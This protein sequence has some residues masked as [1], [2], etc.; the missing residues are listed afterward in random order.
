MQI[1]SS[2]IIIIQSAIA[3]IDT[4]KIH[5]CH[6]AQIKFILLITAYFGGS[7]KMRLH[8][9][10]NSDTHFAASLFSKS[11][12]EKNG[13]NSTQDI[14]WSLATLK[15][16]GFQRVS[17]TKRNTNILISDQCLSLLFFRGAQY[18]RNRLFLQW[19]RKLENPI[20]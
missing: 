1:L 8:M 20:F 19:F 15:I 13:S 2:K 4:S 17:N 14:Y 12:L 11:S 5:K 16:E 6:R 7:G 3:I 10:I 9:E 18:G